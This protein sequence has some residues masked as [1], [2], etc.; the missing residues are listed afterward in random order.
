[1]KT[2]KING[3]L[4]SEEKETILLFDYIEKKWKMDTTVMKHYNKAKKQ[5]WEQTSEYVYDDD[6][7]CGGTFEAPDYA[8]T[9]RSTTKKQMTEKQMGNLS[10]DEE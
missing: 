6:T 9:I 4:T 5:S 10:G 8:V 2:I 3:R 7:V 1:M